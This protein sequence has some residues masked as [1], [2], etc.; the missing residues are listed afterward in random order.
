MTLNGSH[1]D[2][3]TLATCHLEELFD[4]HIVQQNN[5][6][7][8]EC[9]SSLFIEEYAKGIIVCACGQI[10]DDNLFES[11]PDTKNY[12]GGNGYVRS[13]VIHNKL[14]PQSSMSSGIN[15]RGIL[16][17]L[18]KWS[19]MPYKERSD[20]IMFQR[21]HNVCVNNKI[22]KMIEDDAKIL[23]KRVSGT[24]HKIGKNKGSP[25]ITRGYNRA[26]IVAACLFIACRRNNE[27]R[28]IKEIATYFLINEK[29]VNKGI[30]SLLSILDDDNI[31]KDIGTSKII[32]FIKRKCDELHI[33][34][35]Y[36][37]TAIT[38]A[39]NIEKINIASNHT[40][41]SLAAACI[42]LITD[43]HDMKSLTK[44]MISKAFYEL[45]D[46]TIGKTYKQLSNIRSILIDD[47]AIEHIYNDIEIQKKNNIVPK[48]VWDQMERFNI[49]TSNYM[50][51][52]THDVH[53][54][55]DSDTVHDLDTIH[56][57]DIMHDV[58]T[59]HDNVCSMMGD[60]LYCINALNYDTADTDQFMEL[61]Y[62]IDDKFSTIDQ[63]IINL[64]DDIYKI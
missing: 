7:C 38:I 61:L 19:V 56:D 47:V 2:F 10:I 23:C 48:V 41:Y 50:L 21:I 64:Y 52:G 45:S 27:T 51:E 9:G 24:V 53:T 58:H 43:I 36:S 44:K 1:I 15:A 12:E 31:I 42:L 13:G 40:T 20:S 35:E 26:G 60:I 49:D 33:K 57:S 37:K 62:D 32:H 34:T 28:S 16:A 29:D 11:A 63:Y 22:V 59:I 39:R 4:D 18:Y 8:P 46:V 25:I 55:H 3:D 5:D 6:T 30:R 54:I 14:L 17:K